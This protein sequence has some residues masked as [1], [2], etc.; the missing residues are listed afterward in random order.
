MVMDGTSAILGPYLKNIRDTRRVSTIWTKGDTKVD[1]VFGACW[2]KFTLFL[3]QF[4]IQAHSLSVDA[5]ANGI[6]EH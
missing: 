5:V 2:T 6:G 1:L 4:F 3:L